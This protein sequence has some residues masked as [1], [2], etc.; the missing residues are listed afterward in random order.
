MGLTFVLFF[1][2]LYDDLPRG[3]PTSPRAS[4]SSLPLS[5][6]PYL[7]K[8]LNFIGSR[9]NYKKQ[10]FNFLHSMALSI[11]QNARLAIFTIVN[12][13]KSSSMR[14]SAGLASGHS[15]I[16]LLS[17]LRPYDYHEVQYKLT[18]PNFHKMFYKWLLRICHAV[19]YG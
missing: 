9:H 19:V 10:F 13:V 6:L 18:K 7:Q 2:N 5:C 12:A 3:Q 15:H 11:V 16:L 1:Q 17:T 14:T 4:S 8:W